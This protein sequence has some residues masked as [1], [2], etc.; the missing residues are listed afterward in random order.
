MIDISRKRNCKKVASIN[1]FLFQLSYSDLYGWGVACANAFQT[2]C[3]LS[4]DPATANLKQKAILG[5][6]FASAPHYMFLFIMIEVM[7]KEHQQIQ[8]PPLPVMTDEEIAANLH[9]AAPDEDDGVQE[10]LPQ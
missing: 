4:A 1:V 2:S 6:V 10:D 9:E 3:V 7:L 5:A 8:N